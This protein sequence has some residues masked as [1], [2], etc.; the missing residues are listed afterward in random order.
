MKD[1]EARQREIFKA[2]LKTNVAEFA[3]TSNDAMTILSTRKLTGRRDAQ[4]I[5]QSLMS[6]RQPAWA[7]ISVNLHNQLKQLVRETAAHLGTKHSV[8][9]PIDLRYLVDEPILGTPLP[10]WFNGAEVAEHQRVVKALKAG[11]GVN[12]SLLETFTQAAP[13]STSNSAVSAITVT[14]ATAVMNQV[15][16]EIFRLAGVK[17]YKLETS[18]EVKY[19][20]PFELTYGTGEAPQAPLWIGDRSYPVPL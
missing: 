8:H 18:G 2:H 7:A 12:L 11:Y 19:H 4:F 16:L 14:S 13:Y 6:A 9:V 5:A 1:F 17:K 10:R 3:K 15:A 20:E